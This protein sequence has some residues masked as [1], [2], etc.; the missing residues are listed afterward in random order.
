M[1]RGSEDCARTAEHAAVLASG[2]P[3]ARSVELPGAGHS[4][5]IDQPARPSPRFPPHL[6]PQV[7]A[8]LRERIASL[9]PSIGFA[10]AACGADILFL[11]AMQE[12]SRAPKQDVLGS[13]GRETFE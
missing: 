12:A 3:T 7:G 11:E 6:E 10:Q 1:V 9:G 4:P 5:M 8:A 13:I 2:I